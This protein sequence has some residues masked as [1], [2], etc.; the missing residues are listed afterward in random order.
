M[1]SANKMPLEMDV[2]A[3]GIEEA[4]QLKNLLS[5]GRSKIR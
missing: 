2:M 1:P 4:C 3:K 5:L